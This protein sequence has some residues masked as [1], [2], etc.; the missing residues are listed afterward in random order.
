MGLRYQNYETCKCGIGHDSWP[1]TSKTI[2]KKISCKCGEKVGWMSSKQNHLHQSKTGLYGKVDPRFGV[3][4]ADYGE[5]KAYLKEHGIEETDIEHR[6]DIMNDEASVSRGSRDPNMI[7]ADSIEALQ[8]Q[9]AS[10]AYDRANTGSLTGREGQDKD[11]GLID[12][13]RSL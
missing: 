2:P 4:F 7:S 9:I 3:A 8:E 13:W 6:D 10:S 1:V 11:T 12:S 5:K